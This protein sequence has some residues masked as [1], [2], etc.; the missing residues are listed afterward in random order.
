MKCSVSAAP[1]AVVMGTAAFLAGVTP[2]TAKTVSL[3][4]DIQME[5][6]KDHVRQ[7][8]MSGPDDYD[9]DFIVA[10]GGCNYG[11]ECYPEDWRPPGAYRFLNPG[12]IIGIT[13]SIDVTERSDG[14]GWGLASVGSFS[15][16]GGAGCKLGDYATG[17]WLDSKT[18]AFS[19][20]TSGGHESFGKGINLSSMTAWFVSELGDLY[21][22]PTGNC[23]DFDNTPDGFCGY[24]D[25]EAHFK[26]TS[27]T[28][29]GLHVIPVPPALPLLAS[30]LLG[31]AA[32]RRWKTGARS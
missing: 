2:A 32:L 31:L 13:L 29:Q 8:F 17:F 20:S 30:G 11:E 21:A 23:H 7:L 24:W 25:Y 19:L 22:F 6:I 3:T 1:L 18:G 14:S 15:C 4:Y 28:L 9:P 27:F 12:D 5:F 16:T 26:V 10:V